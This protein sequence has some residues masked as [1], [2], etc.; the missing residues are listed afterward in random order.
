MNDNEFRELRVI[1]TA[2]A[3]QAE[4]LQWVNCYAFGRNEGGAYVSLFNA[5]LQYR[6][7]TVYEE[8]FRD[9]P[10]FL[11]DNLPEDLDGVEIST[12]RT[13][14]ERK[15][16]LRPC[17]PFQIARYK[18][19]EGEKAAWRFSGV[20]RIAKAQPEEPHAPEAAP[21]QP[22]QPTP[23]DT[24]RRLG[25]ELYGAEWPEVARRNAY[26]IS[27]GKTDDAAQLTPEQVEKLIAGMLKVKAK[28]SQPPSDADRVQE[29]FDAPTPAE[30]GARPTNASAAMRARIQGQPA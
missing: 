18:V 30:R 29:K 17:T 25:S 12:D 14:L 1:V 2:L 3:Q 21:T 27:G 20:V 10:A 11:R 23:L 8:R 4:L 24:F 19:G 9:L 28:R 5:K 15:G 26:R 13:V 22:A 7:C 6:V 16:I